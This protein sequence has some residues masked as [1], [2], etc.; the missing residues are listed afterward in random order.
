M[1]VEIAMYA[2]GVC[3]YTQ[4]TR[5]KNWVGRYSAWTFVVVLLLLFVADRFNPPP[6]S[7]KQVAQTGAVATLITVAWTWWFDRNR[8]VRREA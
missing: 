3:V 2:A 8:E 6:E 1:V 5:A 7:M 4:A